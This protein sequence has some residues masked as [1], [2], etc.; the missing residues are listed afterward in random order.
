MRVSKINKLLILLKRGMF[1]KVR[2][3]CFDSVC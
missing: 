2:D 3:N 1:G